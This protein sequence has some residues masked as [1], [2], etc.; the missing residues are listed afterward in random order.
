MIGTLGDAAKKSCCV[1][2]KYLTQPLNIANTCGI[3]TI[4]DVIL[5]YLSY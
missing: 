3:F 4:K 1:A 5:E 2:P